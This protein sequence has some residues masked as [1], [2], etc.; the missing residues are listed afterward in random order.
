MESWV[1]HHPAWDVRIWRDGD[2]P[3]LVH[4]EAFEQARSWAQ[5]AD[6]ARYEILLEQG[7]V[8]LDTDMECLRS[9]D[10]LLPGVE[11]FAGWERD[12]LMGNAILG[13]VPGHPWMRTVVE[14]LPGAI[15]ANWLTLD[16]TGPAFLT[17]VTADRT[18]VAVFP[19]VRFYPWGSTEAARDTVPE[20][21]VAIHH[22]NRSWAESEVAMICQAAEQR[23]DEFLPPGVTCVC[24]DGGLPMTWHNERRAL[25]FVERDG[26]D[27]GPP[28]DDAHGLAEV[29]RHR[30]KG[31]EWFVF[32]A[33][34][35]W[36]LDHYADL[37]RSLRAIADQVIEDQTLVAFHLP[38][39]DAG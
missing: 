12:G 10:A 29:Q 25:P 13:C 21:T 34:G 17:N 15:A 32:L 6:I 35:L 36:W 8:Y 7:G 14:A 3:A 9:I 28:A 24:V 5:K 37:A 31:I 30:R 26:I 4:Q 27:H 33:T 20:D 39:P 18:D 22:W 23:L 2:L 1:R 16:Q 11:A 19:P 38:P